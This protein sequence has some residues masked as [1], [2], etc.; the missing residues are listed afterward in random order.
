MTIIRD[1]CPMKQFARWISIVAHP[2]TMITLLVGTCDASTVGPCRPVVLLLGLVVI[3]PIAQY[4]STDLPGRVAG[5]GPI[6]T[7][8]IQ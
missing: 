8:R 2:F 4:C 5:D 6:R 1:H 7:L 3:V